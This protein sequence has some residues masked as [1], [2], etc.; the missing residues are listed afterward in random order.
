MLKIIK[1]VTHTTTTQSIDNNLKR[2]C[3]STDIT[4]KKIHGAIRVEEGLSD[5]LKYFITWKT[6]QFQLSN[7]S[8]P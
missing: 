4:L 2:R 6:T 1:L 8:L 5:Q 3:A 7:L